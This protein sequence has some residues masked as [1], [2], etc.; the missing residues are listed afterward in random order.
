MRPFELDA[1]TAIHDA[2]A[3]YTAR[4]EIDALLDKI[5]WPERHLSLL[6]P[7]AGDGNML[8]A[9]LARLEAPQNDVESVAGRIHGIEFHPPSALRARGRIQEALVQRGWSANEAAEAGE[10]IVEIRDFLLTET[11]ST[12]DVV[13]ANPP[14]FRRTKC[15][16]AWLKLFDERV[17]KRA[18]GDL[19]HAYLDR[20]VDLLNDG[21]RMA[22]ITSD[23]WLLNS[24]ASE[25]RAYL[26][27]RLKV[28]IVERLD[29]SSAFHR[30]KER[31]RGTGP[32]VHPV[33]IVLGP[34]GRHLGRNPLVIDAVPI[35]EGT[36][37]S[38]IAAIR[39][40][41]WL[42][43]DHIFLVDERTRRTLPEAHLV[44]CVEPRDIDPRTDEIGP[45]RRWA[46]VT[47]DNTPPKAVLEHLD[48]HLDA[49]PPRGRRAVRW[50]PPERF[51]GKLPLKE[52]AILIP[53]IAPKLRAV[54]LPAGTLPTNHSLV[55]V[56][57]LSPA[58][59]QAILGDPRVQAQANALVLMVDGGFRSYTASLLRQIVV[60]NDLIGGLKRAA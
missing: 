14:Y 30:P 3:L 40:A 37:F 39:L 45:V 47:D 2:T 29:A 38:D 18:R 1:V 42:G 10:R 25:L 48:A 20:S 59:L 11:S 16:G 27:T 49:M 17:N 6:D 8:I 5:G 31:R 23:R 52:D 13:L 33:S 21:G 56:S 28:E 43:P 19:L 15:P 4:P 54:Q 58:K 26:G 55:V 53:R 7:A 34:N 44:P 12:F 24:G 57:G 35:H 36:P 22:L 60:P 41:P 32:R 46:I 51:D 9:A 50:L